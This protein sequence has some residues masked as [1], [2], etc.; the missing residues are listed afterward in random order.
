MKNQRKRAV[1]ISCVIGKRSIHE[2]LKHKPEKIKAL[3]ITRQGQEDPLVKEAQLLNIPL[4]IKGRDELTQAADS[5]SHQ[6]FLAETLSRAYSSLDEIISRA[7]RQESCLILVLDSITDPHNLGALLRA[8]ECFGVDAVLW[9]K[10]RGASVTPVVTKTSVGATEL[11]PIILVSNLAES[12]RKLQKEGFW[13]ST[14]E[15]CEGATSLEEA[16]FPLF[17][18][19]IMGSEGEGVQPLLSKMA[20]QKIYIPMIGKIGSLNVSQAAAVVLSKNRVLK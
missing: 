19:I 17:H 5:D 10:N 4:V 8:A 11:L 18:A 7:R 6:G 3:W 20:D 16:S 15:L 12:I 9:S 14:T 2:L 13:V 1:S